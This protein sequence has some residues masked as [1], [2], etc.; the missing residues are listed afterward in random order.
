MA[1]IS[2][3]GAGAAAGASTAL[4]GVAL[5]F[6]L[7]LG[8][9]IAGGIWGFGAVAASGGAAQVLAA[10]GGVVMGGIVGRLAILP[11]IGASLML[12]GAIGVTTALIGKTVSS[13]G[14]LIKK[15]FQILGKKL[16]KAKKAKQEK[17]PSR[18]HAFQVPIKTS[19]SNKSKKQ[20]FNAANQNI[21]KKQVQKTSVNNKNQ[22]KI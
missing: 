12:G 16:S 1:K 22:P 19:S 17:A 20:D 15:P 2:I 8:G 6:A 9:A 5:S 18:A 7:P 14:S 11:A 13:G 21:G 3:K 10:V 4:L